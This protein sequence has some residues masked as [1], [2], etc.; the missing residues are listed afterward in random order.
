MIENWQ[1]LEQWICEQ[2]KDLD[3]YIKRTPG[4]GNK[5]CKGDIKFS[6]NLGLHIEAKWRNLKSVF[7][8]DWLKKCEEE[9]PLHSKKIAVLITENKDGIKIVHLKAED[10]FRLFKDAYYYRNPTMN[11]L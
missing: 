6:T 3:P 4:S 5:G 11:G 2:L 1:K 8:I 9:I 7:N 10:F